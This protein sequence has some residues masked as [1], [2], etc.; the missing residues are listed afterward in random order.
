[1]FLSIHIWISICMGCVRCDGICVGGGNSDSGSGIGV[2]MCDV[3][4]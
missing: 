2:F 3:S 1:M 4:G